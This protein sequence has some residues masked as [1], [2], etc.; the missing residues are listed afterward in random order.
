MSMSSGPSALDQ[1]GAQRKAIR[2]AADQVL[3]EQA[4]KTRD[5]QAVKKDAASIMY[6][7]RSST[8]LATRPTPALPPTSGLN[9]GKT[10]L[11]S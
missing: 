10:Y 4:T 7:G 5:E 3:L 9:G 1:M 8:Q 2:E 11:G 6:G